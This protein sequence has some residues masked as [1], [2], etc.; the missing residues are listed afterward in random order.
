MCWGRS[1]KEQPERGHPGVKLPACGRRNFLEIGRQLFEKVRR[2]LFQ[3]G[4]AR[5]KY[6]AERKR[7]LDAF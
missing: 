6:A 5:G 7:L 3:L 4:H 1:A 2:H